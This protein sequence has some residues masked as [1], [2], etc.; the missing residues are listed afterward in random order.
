MIQQVILRNNV[1]LCEQHGCCQCD[2]LSASLKKKPL[3]INTKPTT[4]LVK[5]LHVETVTGRL[6]CYKPVCSA[7]L[8]LIAGNQALAG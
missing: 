2:T 3:S 1:S 4:K 7:L 8:R 5:C 6:Q